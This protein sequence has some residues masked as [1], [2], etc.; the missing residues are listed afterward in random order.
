VQ[1]VAAA[2]FAAFRRAAANAKVP[3]A[4]TH[5]AVFAE[6]HV[7]LANG[8]G[9]VIV[10]L[11]FGEEKNVFVIDS[12]ARLG[13]RG[14]GIGFVPYAIGAKDPAVVDEGERDAPGQA[15]LST[16]VV[17]VADDDPEGAGWFHRAAAFTEYGYQPLDIFCRRFFAADLFGLAAVIALLP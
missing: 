5:A 15:E 1:I 16:I 12:G 9:V 8:V 7:W 6:G 10:V 3:P 2:V 14:H 4:A 17:F 13:G 11:R